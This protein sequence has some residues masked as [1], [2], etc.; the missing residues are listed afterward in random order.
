MRSARFVLFASLGCGI[1]LAIS[2]VHG[3][4]SPKLRTLKFLLANGRRTESV[5]AA[6]YH[7]GFAARRGRPNSDLGV[8]RQLERNARIAVGKPTYRS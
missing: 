7:N 3:Q 5:S 8:T 2:G 6:I 4:T 1:L